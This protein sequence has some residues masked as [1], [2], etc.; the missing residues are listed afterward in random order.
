MINWFRRKNRGEKE[1]PVSEKPLLEIARIISGDDEAVMLDADLCVSAPTAWFSLHERRFQE[2][3]LFHIERADDLDLVRWLGLVDILEEHEHVCE[4]DWKDEKEDFVYFLSRLSGTRR[5]RLSIQ[6]KWLNEQEDIWHWSCVL[7]RKWRAQQCCVA[8]M[9]IDSDSYVLFPCRLSD[10]E[11]LRR[12]AAQE[13]EVIDMVGD[14]APEPDQDHLSPNLLR[15][16]FQK[17]KKP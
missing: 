12:L 4:R 7:N 17:K 14:S 13:G 6:D 9:D 3:Q 8:A 5:L 1:Q 10:L 15:A 11:K 16:I 2:R